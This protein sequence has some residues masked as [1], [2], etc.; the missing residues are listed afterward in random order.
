M[1]QNCQA[2]GQK[3]YWY[4]HLA[5]ECILFEIIDSFEWKTEQSDVDTNISWSLTVSTAISTLLGYGLVNVL[6]LTDTI[7]L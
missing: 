1:L 4:W 6:V 3:V 5:S 7:Q 2:F